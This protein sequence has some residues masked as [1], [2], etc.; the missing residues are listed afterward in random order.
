MSCTM[1]CVK[2]WWTQ[3]ERRRWGVR[4]SMNACSGRGISLIPWIWGRGLLLSRTWRGK[5]AGINRHEIRRTRSQKQMSRFPCFRAI[6]SLPQNS[7]SPQDSSPLSTWV[8]STCSLTST[9]HQTLSVTHFRTGMWIWTALI[10]LLWGI[11]R[12]WGV[13]L[14]PGQRRVLSLVI[15]LLRMCIIEFLRMKLA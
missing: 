12:L 5:Q 3:E 10:W 9:L 1:T 15:R 11:R 2:R 14:C 6:S 8:R 7:T 13:R 4:S